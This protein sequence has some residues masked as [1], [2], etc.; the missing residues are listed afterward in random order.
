MTLMNAELQGV[1]FGLPDSAYYAAWADWGEALTPFL[2]DAA[3]A[4][5]RL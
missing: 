5:V 3:R 4:K 2:E 1:A